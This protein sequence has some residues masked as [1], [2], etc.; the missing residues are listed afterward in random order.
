[1]SQRVASGVGC[2][3]CSTQSWTDHEIGSQ[4]QSKKK[5]VLKSS[6]TVFH[7]RLGDHRSELAVNLDTHSSVGQI[8][9]IYPWSSVW[10]R[11]SLIAR[12]V[13]SEGLKSE[14][15][16]AQNIVG[17]HVLHSA[18]AN[19]TAKSWL[20]WNYIAYMY[21]YLSIYIYVYIIYRYR[22]CQPA[23]SAKPMFAIPWNNQ[24]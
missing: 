9:H 11:G 20:V 13:F 16:R 12:L 17:E 22:H 23:L 1:M 6:S 2:P 5:N 4:S 14:S 10:G 19:H 8:H 15:E 7:G 21:I 3:T 18:T 24:R